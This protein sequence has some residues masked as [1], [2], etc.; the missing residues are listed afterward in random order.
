MR[1]RGLKL[2]NSSRTSRTHR[3]APHAGAWIETLPGNDTAYHS[4]VAPHAGAW[5]ET[6]R[7]LLFG[8]LSWSPP[9]RGRGLKHLLPDFAGITVSV[10]PH[11]GA[12]IETYVF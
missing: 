6:L 5:I 11:A 7:G 10:A 3:V 4:F 8:L 12:W 9:M 1:G 2:R